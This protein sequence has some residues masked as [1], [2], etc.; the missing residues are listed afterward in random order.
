MIL[1]F[2]LSAK[3]LNN[4]LKII[5]GKYKSR[6]IQIPDK[7][8]LRPSKAYIR[9][10]LFNVLDIH[11]CNSSLDLFSGSGILSFEAI[12]RGIKKSVLI[13]NDTE[14]VQCIK[15]NI[16]LLDL[17]DIGV[18]KQKVEHY[19]KSCINKSYDIIF[20]DPPYKTKLLGETLEILKKN[21]FLESNKYLY[22]ERSKKD[23]GDYVSY[24]SDT[25]LILKDLSIGDVSYTISK[26]KNL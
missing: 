11:L 2:L 19:L 21:N 8:N 1:L 5:S 6:F 18:V 13:E 23:S 4:K 20:I 22:F 16:Q 9:E 17:Q 3:L 26:N 14:L 7:K 24:I 15:K 25:H 10:S 12:S